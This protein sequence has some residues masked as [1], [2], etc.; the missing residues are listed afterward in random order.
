MFASSISL[1]T[2]LKAASS[3]RSVTGVQPVPPEI[4]PQI[5]DQLRELYV[6]L[7]NNPAAARAFQEK[8]DA[9]D[10]VPSS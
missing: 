8:L 3:S 2:M 4:G 5:G 7:K 10:A 9:L 1:P 6:Y